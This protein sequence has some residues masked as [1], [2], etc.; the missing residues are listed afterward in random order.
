MTFL[1]AASAPAQVA[2]NAIVVVIDGMRNDEGFESESLY[3]RHIWNDLRP[4]GTINTKFW[5]RGWTATTGGHTTILSGVRQVL[6]NNGSNEQ[7]IRSFDPLMFEY[8]RQSTGAPEAACGVVVGKWGNVG[9]IAD[10]GLEP[11][12]GEPFKGFQRGDTS[13]SED[14]A[15]MRLLRNAMDSLQPRLVLINLGDVDHYGHID[16]LTGGE[17]YRQAIV[18]ADSL[19]YDLWRRIQAEPPYTDTFYRNRTALYVLSDHGRHDDAHGGFRGHGNWDHGSRHVMFLALGPGIAPNRM[20]T[21]TPR[22]QIDLVPTIA[23][24]L[25][26]AAPF[27]EGEVMTEIFSDGIAPTLS[28]GE[29][30]ALPLALNLSNSSGFSR[31]PDVCRD[32]SGNLHLV[33]SDNTPG[34]W[35]VQYRKSS[36]EG[37]TWSAPATMFDYPEP[38]SVM[39]YARVAADD[40]VAI[41]ATGYGKR[42]NYVDSLPTGR[43]DTT[44]LW[45]P[46]IATSADNG[47]SWNTTSL[48]D[49]SMGSYYPALSV[50]N[51]RY[52]LAWWMCGKFAA[53]TTANGMY[54]NSRPGGG[55]WR[56]LPDRL[57]GKNS[58]HLSCADNGTTWHVVGAVFQVDDWDLVDYRSTNGDT[59]VRTWIVNDGAGNPT[60]DYDPEVVIDDTGFTH[61]V[62]ARKPDETGVWQ[63]MY[64]R[65]D[66][67]AGPFDTFRLTASTAGA[68]QPHIAAKGCTL[69]LVWIDYQ[70]GNPE[71]YCKFST[72]RGLAW[73]PAERIT[74]GAALTHHPRVASAGSGFYA[75]WQDLTS[76]NWEVYGRKIT[77]PAGRDVGVTAIITPAGTLDSTV[78]VAPVAQFTNW[79]VGP[80]S[81]KTWFRIAD[82]SGDTVYF[83]S[84]VVTDLDPGAIGS[85]AF[86]TWP[87]PHALGS[88]SCWCWLSYL[89][90][91]NPANDIM[92]GGFSVVQPPPSWSARA[93]LPFGARMKNVKD[94][95]ALCAG[96]EPT[97]ADDTTYVYALK[98]NNTCEFYRYNTLTDAWVA[99]ESIPALNRL[100]KKKA[101]KK[102]SSLAFGTNGKLY[103]TKGN[104]T[105]DFWEYSPGVGGPG[106]G[107]WLQK[108]DVPIGAKRCREGVGAVAAKE[109]AVNYIYLL[110]GSGTFEFYRYNAGD[111]TWDATLPFAPGGLSGKAYKNGSCLAYDGE[112]TIY[113]LKGSYNEFPAYSIQGKAWTTKNPLPLT[114][115]PGTRKKKVKDGAGMACYGD[116]AYALKGGNTNEFWMFSSADQLWHVQTELPV[117]IK[118]VKGGGALT[119]AP[120]VGALYAFRGNN[121]REFWRYGPLS[122]D[123]YPLS[124]NRELKSIQGPTAVR[125]PQFA[126]SISPNPVTSSL[127]PSISYSLP[128]AGNVSLKLFDVTGKLKAVLAK[129]YHPAGSY[130]SQLT[131][132]SSRPGLARG[133]Y[134]LKYE[135]GEYRATEK[136]VIE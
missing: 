59:W 57:V 21:G 82:A 11:A 47:S 104:G 58:V 38:D 51:G 108:A 68:W 22:D 7:H 70:D 53:E 103:A 89:G 130:S 122:A 52:G 3:L 50:K 19:V 64:A 28:R 131:A 2:Q 46:W 91:V 126:L 65:L 123:R 98:G 109:G 93:E 73:S 77:Y 129:G 35:T 45:Y 12:Y 15:S 76:G 1:L 61:V 114:A 88:F 133:V 13:T 17:L 110:K 69:A 84:S 26:F 115:P 40:S 80:A 100:S 4:Q 97:D 39:W 75:V 62:W 55:A 25:G 5:D 112:D 120:D 132:G 102:G 41:A 27:A 85:A 135:A 29:E 49:S 14:T 66:S 72:D 33:W 124:A 87:K 30:P 67:V 113:C 8:Y 118:K 63:V 18:T 105:L 9:D 42:A 56:P 99:K 71:L 78:D 74:Y 128:V 43:M 116:A 94:G 111:N 31:D 119:A 20:V 101:V 121:T 136:L 32:R 37:R 34:K 60:Y 127:N 117:G 107:V 106:S 36:D 92:G 79:G 48:F 96:K 125:S 95:G 23:A 16:S 90:D 86:P 81:F 10:F 54:F 83:D 134:L 44:F 6:L 24:Q